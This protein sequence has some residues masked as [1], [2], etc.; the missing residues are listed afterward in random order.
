MTKEKIFSEVYWFIN[1]MGEEYINKLPKKCY[2]LIKENADENISL[3]CDD[4]SSINEKNFSKE[5]LSM[6]VLLYLNY[7]CDNEN[8]KI[9]LRDILKQNQREKEEKFAYSELFKNK[10]ANKNYARNVETESKV[11]ENQLIV[12]KENII[13]RIF[14][15]IK[16]ILKFK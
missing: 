8:D 2:K 9:E 15:K 4:I 12:V 10:K 1:N 3:D 13:K 6:I 16:N 7:W 5:A 11:K 14:K